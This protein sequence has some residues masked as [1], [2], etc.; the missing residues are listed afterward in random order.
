M[1]Y[2]FNENEQIKCPIC[3]ESANYREFPDVVRL[4]EQLEKYKKYEIISELFVDEQG[5]KYRQMWGW[6]DNMVNANGMEYNRVWKVQV[7]KLMYDLEQKYFPKEE[8]T[9]DKG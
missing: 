9:N 1:D 7:G 5:D 2:K 4:V 3:G 6:L 8:A